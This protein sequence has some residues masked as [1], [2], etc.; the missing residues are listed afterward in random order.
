MKT[1]EE[2]YRE[3]VERFTLE[4]GMEVSGTGEMAVRLYALAAQLYGLYE[5]NAWTRKQCFPQTAAGEELDKHAALRGLTRNEAV[6]AAGTLRFSVETAADRA[7]TVPAGTV[8]M[9]A[10]LV[11]YETTQTGTIA[12]GALSVD[13]PARAVEAG[14]G[15]NTSANTIRSMAVAPLGVAACTNPAPFTGGAETEGDEALRQRVLDT[16]R[17]MPNGTNAAYYEQQALAVD[18]VAAVKVLGKNRGL[19]TVDVV[20]AS[21]D[22]LPSSA[23][24]AAVQAA[25]EEK[26]EIAV[27]VLVLAPTTVTVN[28]TVQVKAKSGYD[29]TAVR[30]EVTERL[31]A[32]FDGTRLGR[33]VLL[34]ELGQLV[35]SVDGVENYRITAP[36]S[37]RTVTAGQLPVSG[38]LRVE[39]M[40]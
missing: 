13:V 40:T 21:P 35:Y 23:L 9:T 24:V 25:L 31:S 5:E 6:K 10:G 16:Y 2:L 36:S 37:D 38:T 32:W 29:G 4:T 18:G 22:G 26:R 33:S 11:S 3:M 7:L 34:A 19:G 30:A 8:C 28:V 14:A 39:A 12:E 15:G 17:R 1:V 27:D 20:I